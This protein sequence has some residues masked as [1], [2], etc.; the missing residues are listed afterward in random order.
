MKEFAEQLINYRKNLN[1]T[2]QQVSE[3]T[4]IRP[5]ILEELESGNFTFLP[6]VYI[7]SFIKTYATFLKL[8]DEDIDLM[9]ESLKSISNIKKPAQY[10]S[11]PLDNSSNQ[12]EFAKTPASIFPK[13]FGSL[14]NSN[15]INYLIYSALGL[16]I[17]VLIYITFFMDGS[18]KRKFSGEKEVLGP[19]TAIIKTQG[20]A[21]VQSIAQPDSIQLEAYGKDTAWIKIIID[22]QKMDQFTIYPSVEKKWYAKEFFLLSIGN[23]GAVIFKRNGVQLQPF[24]TKGTIIRNIKITRDK[25]DI[26]SSPWSQKPDTSSVPKKPRTRKQEEKKPAIRLIDPSPINSEKPKIKNHN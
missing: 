8:P 18:A 11:V 22:G 16:T 13:K 4:K 6:A 3:K 1:L 10:Q 26:S 20:K 17:V 23:E 25:I 15:I 24:G 12:T 19:D 14:K 9:L 7:I 2:I 21:I 5:H